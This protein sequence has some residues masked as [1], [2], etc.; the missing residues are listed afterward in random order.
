MLFLV[1]FMLA[2][3]FL[4]AVTVVA[5][6]IWWGKRNAS[7]P[8]RDGVL[9][10]VAIGLGF[11]LVEMAMMQQ[12]AIFLGQPIL[13]THCSCCGADSFI[14][15]RQP[16]VRRTEA[17]VQSREPPA[18][19]C[20]SSHGLRVFLGCFAGD[21]SFHR[22]RACTAR[23]HLAPAGYATGFC[24]GFLLPRW[25]ALVQDSW[26]RKE[27]ALDV[28]IKWRCRNFWQLYRDSAFDGHQYRHM[29][30]GRRGLLS[31]GSGCDAWPHYGSY[32]VDIVTGLGTDFRRHRSPG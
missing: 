15:P 6:I 27:P 28:G 4:V 26:R 20:C 2:A 7:R 24:N 25:P 1:A 10:F 9:Y 5:P 14:R 13:L 32:R 30:V 12:L 21:T 18:C 19:I 16:R 22:W 8:P 3:A 11:M 31:P 23:P 17:A 29:H